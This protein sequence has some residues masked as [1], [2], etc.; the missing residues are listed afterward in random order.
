MFRILV[1]WLCK[2]SSR[3]TSRLLESAQRQWI[4]VS[5]PKGRVDGVIKVATS[6]HVLM[7]PWRRKHPWQ[8]LVLRPKRWHEIL[9]GF[10]DSQTCRSETCHKICIKILL[11]DISLLDVLSFIESPQVFHALNLRPHLYSRN[12]VP[13]G[14]TSNFQWL[15]PQSV[16]NVMFYGDDLGDGGVLWGGL[17][18]SFQYFLIQEF[19]REVHNFCIYHRSPRRW[20]L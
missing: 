10:V 12:D 18:I 3:S 14:V 8:G 17:W 16:W 13:K 20:W 4:N 15:G 5:N 6:P 19:F 1:D 2:L 7:P 11:D 9:K